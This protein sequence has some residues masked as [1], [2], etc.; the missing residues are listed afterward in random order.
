MLQFSFQT[1]TTEA[2]ISFQAEA[3]VPV[4][5]EQ[6]RA[7]V[8][9]GVKEVVDLMGPGGEVSDVKRLNDSPPGQWVQ[10]NPRTWQVFQEAR[11]WHG[12][13]CGA[14]DPTSGAIKKMF[15]FEGG[16]L[17]KWPEERRLDEAAA[18]V[19]LDKI[20]VRPEDRS[21]ALT[22]I[23]QRLD[24]GAIAKGYAVDRA[25]EI[26]L[27]NG[28]KNG[29]VEIGGEI[30]VLG[31]HPGPPPRPWRIGLEDPL[32]GGNTKFKL[33]LSNA[34]VAA[35]SGLNRFFTYEGRRYSHIIDPRASRP[36]PGKTLGVTVAHPSSCM[37]ADALSTALWILGPEEGRLCLERY[38]AARG[39]EAPG[40]QAVVFSLNR[41]GAGE[42][43]FLSI[44][45][46]GVST[47]PLDFN[48]AS[49]QNKF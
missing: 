17:L 43:L 18:L 6:I 20:M 28:V 49:P 16:F 12:F 37:T 47:R 38:Q 3:G 25:A 48:S 23:G 45:E 9:A 26:L 14:F 1:M 7:R 36:L 2:H 21:L 30:R 42:G 13:S 46:K 35:S 44:D 31:L 39:P 10:L 29:L 34:A 15:I 5:A 11:L 22:R 27:E 24:L 33:E 40:T 19:G 4:A 32:S 41:N 8:E